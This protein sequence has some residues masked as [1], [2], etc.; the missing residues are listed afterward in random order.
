[1]SVKPT[2]YLSTHHLRSE[3]LDQRKN[4]HFKRRQDLILFETVLRLIYLKQKPLE[5]GFVCI[6]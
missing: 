3:S 1:M 4:P 2:K 5:S 6:W